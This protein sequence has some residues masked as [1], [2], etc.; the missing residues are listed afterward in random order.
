MLVKDNL[1]QFFIVYFLCNAT[2]SDA[3]LF[4]HMIDGEIIQRLNSDKVNERVLGKRNYYK[5]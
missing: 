2:F 1:F 5:I 3:K 4:P